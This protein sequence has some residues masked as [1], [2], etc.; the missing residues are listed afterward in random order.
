MRG[1]R[2][3][4]VTAF[5]L[6]LREPIAA[7][8]T[9]G[10]PVMLVILFGS[11]YGNEPAAIFSGR[12][13]MD[14]SMPAYT[15][16]ILGTVGLLGVPI[17]IAS[18]REQGVL[19]RFRATPMRP[20]TF[21]TADILTNL[22]MT[23]L[24]M[25]LLFAVGWLLYRVRFEGHFL[26]LALGVALSAVAVFAVGYLI[27]SLAA[28]ARLA[29]VIGLVIFYPMTFLSG[30]AM[31]IEILPQSIRR[32]SEY[33]PLTYAVRLIKG[34]WFGDSWSAHL[35]DVGVLTGILVV[36]GALAARFYRWE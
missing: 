36:F 9:L 6:Y 14:V 4:T 34:L 1:L 23:F 12:G 2:Q 30:A 22:G 5:K 26:S 8:F 10:F 32:I 19:R 13:S 16:L 35:V 29:Q 17:T 18:Y 28:S 24:G 7:F 11:I 31:P 3:L 20:L 15:A 25:I 27:A 33:L 21:I